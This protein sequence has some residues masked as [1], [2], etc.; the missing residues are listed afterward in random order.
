[1]SKTHK[2]NK[3]YFSGQHIPT[4]ELEGSAGYEEHATDVSQFGYTDPNSCTGAYDHNAA[5]QYSSENTRYTISTN[6]NK[7][8]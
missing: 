3:P 8:Y 7:I 1:M 5:G 4:I 2:I 6:W